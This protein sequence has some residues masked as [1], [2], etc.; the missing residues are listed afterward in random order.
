VLFRGANF[1]IK[2]IL[3]AGRRRH[4]EYKEGLQK[5]LEATT[6]ADLL[7]HFTPRDI[8]IADVC[9][10]IFK[11]ARALA[12]DKYTA[13]AVRKGLDL[14]FYVNLNDVFGLVEAPFAELTPL[15]SL[16]YRS[17]AFVM[18]Y[19]SSTLVAKADAP[20]FIK[21][22]LRNIVHRRLDDDAASNL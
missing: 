2:E 16:G 6:P 17:V 10:L 8:L 13:A 12:D 9:A 7:E 21:S 18:G 20:S 4:Q 15:D 5:A 14:L 19:R 11:E 22:A 1:E 3:S